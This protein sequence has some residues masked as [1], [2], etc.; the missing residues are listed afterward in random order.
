M[1]QSKRKTLIGAVSLA[2]LAPLASAQMLEEV[3]VTAQKREQTLKDVPISIS[4][5][6]GKT[7]ENRSID[8]LASLSSSIPNFFISENQIDST[9]S[10]RGVTTGNNKGFEQSVAMYF[11]GISY[12]RSQL[13]RTPLF[14]LERVEVLRGPQGILFG[15]N[16]LAGAINVRSAAPVVGEGL[17]GR[18]AASFESDNGE[19]FEGHVVSLFQIR[20]IIKHLYSWK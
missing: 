8:D 13:I 1:I 6:S 18:V 5:V 16:T 2:V 20:V 11:D 10:I 15:K 9:L 19:Y 17:S 14:D 4:A 12:G 7:I 3:V